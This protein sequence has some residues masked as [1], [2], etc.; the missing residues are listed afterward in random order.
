MF[1]FAVASSGV[2]LLS[3]LIMGCAPD[4]EPQAGRDHSEAAP[5]AGQSEPV[6]GAERFSEADEALHL[7]RFQRL[8]EAARLGAS[9]DGYDPLAPVAGAGEL[10]A[11]PQADVDARSIDAAA[12]EDARRYA[13]RMNSNALVV[14]HAGKVE[15]EEYFGEHTRESLVVS[16]SL[17][18]P[19]TAI[20][21]G[22]AMAL[23]HITSLDQ[24]VAAFIDEWRG[25]AVREQMLLRHLLDMRTGFLPQGLSP[26]PQHILN[27]A[28]LHPRHDEV[29]IHDYPVVDDPGTRYEYSNATSEL[30]AVVIQRATGMRYEDFLSKEVLQP[31]GAAGGEI[32]LN[33][34]EGVAHAGCCI[35]LPAQTWMRLA[36]LLLDEGAWEGR[37]LLPEGYVAEMKTGTP[38]NVRYGLGVYLPGPYTQRRPFGNLERQPEL[39]PGILHSEPY[40]A[41]DLFMF[42][43][44]ASQVVYIVPSQRLIILR[45]GGNPPRDDEWDNSYL[46]NLLLPALRGFPG[47]SSP[48]ASTS[49]SQASMGDAAGS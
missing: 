7:A 2:V 44:N 31:I 14:W 38:Q 17:A 23:G 46:P 12:L 28:Y 13:Q 32:W 8:M 35:L 45:T 15:L 49:S 41:D 9:L 25:D 4:P 26:D 11:L 47:E 34:P 1:R 40:L 24:P 22:R 42:D 18:K 29:I 39:G 48:Q 3:W 10:V 27:R 16:R 21:V 19:L 20:A 33:R 30:I 37:Q 6:P 43:G 5:V 36:I